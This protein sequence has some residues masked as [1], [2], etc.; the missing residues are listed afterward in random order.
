MRFAI[1]GPLEISADD[2][3]PVVVS[4]R[5]HRSTLCLLLLNAG[6]PCS[7]NSLISALW[8]DSPPLRPDVSLRSCVYG[9]RKL[10]PDGRRLVTH[11]SGYLIQVHPGELDLHSF[12]ELVVRGR[13]ALDGGNPL[14]AATMLAQALDLWRDPPVADLP[15]S[16]DKDKLLDQR[17]VAQDALMDARLALGRHRQVLSELRSLVTADPLREHAWA[18]LM[19]A[20]YRCGA[21]AEALAAFGRLRMTLV[22]TYGIEPGPELQDLHRKVLA[23]DP[24]LMPRSQP[25]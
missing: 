15:E 8:G 14:D 17:K 11:P 21:R 18:Q 20:L 12:R 10:L 25:A 1:L 19:T 6:Q 16:R 2:D 23:D 3:S 22:T 5:M 7:V 4:R 24:D 13:D 9:I